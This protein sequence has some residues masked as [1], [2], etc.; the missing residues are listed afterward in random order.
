MFPRQ[1]TRPSQMPQIWASPMASERK[2][3]IDSPPGAGISK[4]PSARAAA[5]DPKG[6]GVIRPQQRNRACGLEP[7]V[8]RMIWKQVCRVPDSMS[9]TF[10]S[11][12]SFILKATGPFV[13]TA[14][15]AASVD[16]L[17]QRWSADKESL[18]PAGGMGR[19]SRGVP[20]PN[21]P[22]QRGGSEPSNQRQRPK[23]LA[24]EPAILASVEKTCLGR[25]D[26]KSPILPEQWS[27]WAL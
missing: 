23:S 6:C 18:A 20:S 13:Q 14:R 3:I 9:P 2:A 12:A 11:F 25:V 17:Q 26:L 27:S 7:L 1:Y 24:V 21:L 8:W 4:L 22:R 19:V 10:S 5:S 16:V 15:H